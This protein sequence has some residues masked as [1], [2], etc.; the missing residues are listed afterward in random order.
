MKFL[1][2]ATH[3]L[4]TMLFAVL[5]TAMPLQAQTK[6]EGPWWPNKLWG[7]GDQ[8]GGSNWI[9]P[10]KIVKALSLVKTGKTFELGHPYE[11]GMPMPGQRSYNIFIPSFPTYAPTGNDK[12][13][14]NDEYITSEIGQVGTQFDGPGHVGRQMT[15]TD[16]STANIFYNGVNGEEMKSSYG[17][18]KLGVENVKPI[19]T[20]A[21]LIDLAAY[22]GVN[23]MPENYE[24]TLTDVRNTLARQGMK[25]SDIEPGD[26]V[27]FNL[28]WWRIWPDKK[29]VQATAAYAGRELIDWLI[30]MK[31]SMVGSDAS[32]DAGPDYLLH[33]ELILK[34]GIFNLEFMNFESMATE[35]QQHKFLFIF[36]PLR[37][38]GA[39]GSPGRPLGIY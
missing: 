34:N 36:T 10:E 3:L 15:M 27:L 38:K 33:E 12:V 13:A 17:L 4:L 28:G 18:Q 23:T 24:I 25:E 16:G 20:R 9:T 22:K 5:I 11:R 19:I 35:K 8:A 37:L 21:I 6:N 39:T 2:S 7:T 31:P 30:L 26:A 1:L 32:L 29:T 14:F